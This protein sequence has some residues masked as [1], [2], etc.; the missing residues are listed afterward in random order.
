MDVKR[1]LEILESYL[2]QMA[3]RAEIE[4]WIGENIDFSKFKSP[5]QAMGPIMK[6]YGK[7]ADGNLVKEILQ[8]ITK[9]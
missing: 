7:L 3:E 9:R 5:M 1:Y 4:S 6:H 2:P 8:E